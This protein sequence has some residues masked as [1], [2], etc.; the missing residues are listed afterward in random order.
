MDKGQLNL[1]GKGE[2]EE[3]TVGWGLGAGEEY[4]RKTYACNA[5][6][7]DTEWC[8]SFAETIT[9]AIYIFR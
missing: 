8:G 2:S 1:T 4:G 5:N 7:R 6:L 9:I 3:D